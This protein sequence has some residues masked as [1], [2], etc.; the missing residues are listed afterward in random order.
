MH[1]AAVISRK[2][3]AFFDLICSVNELHVLQHELSI[4]EIEQ[5]NKLL[6]KFDLSIHEKQQ[7]NQAYQFFV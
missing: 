6:K 3:Q 4:L 5:I 1:Q 2:E 7:T